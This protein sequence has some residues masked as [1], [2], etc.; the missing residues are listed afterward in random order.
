MSSGKFAGPQTSENL[1]S[2]SKDL[3]LGALASVSPPARQKGVHRAKNYRP[4]WNCEVDALRKEILCIRHQQKA[5]KA[6]GVVDAARDKNLKT[7][8]TKMKRDSRW[9]REKYNRAE[10]LKLIEI[11]R[12]KTKRKVLWD[13]V[14]GRSK[15]SFDGI[16]KT[17]ELADKDG[18]LISDAP[19]VCE[20]FRSEYEHLGSDKPPPGNTF[21]LEE[22]ERQI[23]AY[24]SIKRLALY[25]GPADGPIN[26][27]EI[28][29]C[30][31]HLKYGK[32]SGLDHISTDVLK[33]AH[34]PIA[35]IFVVLFNR[36][37]STGLPPADWGKAAVAII[38][39]A[40]DP[41]DWANYRLISLLSVVGKLFEAVLNRR[42]V[43]LL[44]KESLLNQE[45]I[46]CR[47]KGYRCQD[48]TFVLA[49]TIKSMARRRKKT[50]CGFLDVRKAYPTV[51]RADLMEKLH[52]KLSKASGGDSRYRC[53]LWSVIDKLY[54]N[55][56]SR[57]VIQDSVSDEYNVN[58]GLREGSVLSPILYAI[59][60]DGI[61]AEM[62]GCIGVHVH[63]F[64][65]KALLY[66]D[67]IVLVSES[68]EDLQN[69][70][71]CCQKYAD[72]HSFQF[73]MKK[74]QVVV[75]GQDE[76][77]DFQWKLMGENMSQV[78]HYKY[79]GLTFR[80]CLG[81]SAIH[82][83]TLALLRLKYVGRKFIDDGPN[84]CLVCHKSTLQ[85]DNTS[86]IAT[87]L[88]CDSCEGDVHRECMGTSPVPPGD[89]NCPACRAKNAPCFPIPEERIITSIRLE[90]FS[91]GKLEYH[92]VT[93]LIDGDNPHRNEYAFTLE[94]LHEIMDGNIT[95]YSQKYGVRQ[96]P[97]FGTE[98]PWEE[99]KANTKRK[100]SI[101]R[102]QL[103][104]M[105]CHT[106]G[107]PAWISKQVVQTLVVATAMFNTEIWQDGAYCPEIQ[108]EMN[109]IY[110]RLIDVPSC[111]NN[112]AIHHE[113]GL[114]DQEFR[115]KVAA[116][117]FRN[118]VIGLPAHRLVK[119]M[120]TAL[121][122]EAAPA[123][124]HGRN[125]DSSVITYL[126][127]LALKL[128]W[129]GNI[130]ACAAT[131]KAHETRCFLQKE[132]LAGLSADSATLVAL[133]RLSSTPKTAPYLLRDPSLYWSHRLG[134]ALKIK[135][136]CNCREALGKGHNLREVKGR[137]TRANSHTSTPC[138]HQ[139]IGESVHHVLGVCGAYKAPR[140]ACFARIETKVPSFVDLTTTQKVDYVLS[141][142]NSPAVDID[143]Y[144]FLYKVHHIRAKLVDPTR[145]GIGPSGLDGSPSG[146][147]AL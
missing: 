138:C 92:A 23:S 49:E 88:H 18:H 38:F 118:H 54:E 45:Q 79:L 46:G 37:L 71:D 134:K 62:H 43:S 42:I 122:A 113:C 35:R 99:A 141:D 89:F 65:Y 116:L 68:A 139:K 14:L 25:Q 119:Q 109:K 28:T 20:K 3:I 15:Q 146:L 13:V 24:G 95:A 61:I 144:R 84:T 4:W 59:F 8:K 123:L 48:H 51:L 114:I 36:A 96:V 32:A 5:D 82:G 80:R 120:Y 66:V 50:F 105:G 22:R 102:N 67:D 87:V 85:A 131:I 129:R 78:A 76:D 145:P 81:H 126:E 7:L 1:W 69:M 53:H 70:L 128:H 26:F 10:N 143:I 103:D 91:S 108:I 39:K 29:Q 56:S 41:T 142:N 34:E 57:V 127:P 44:D 63:R 40:G 135:L 74:S 75:F 90:R 132:K 31:K 106:M 33:I 97:L 52:S 121:L 133:K 107:L 86:V 27:D 93:E 101:L 83:S 140:D 124:K 47:G 125:V 110:R 77:F 19:S 64:W 6:S 73:S 2:T 21:N 94:K 115:A 98:D 112:A 136:R 137:L 147:P 16:A 9:A 17:I 60:I 58:H 111:T 72:E 100:L 130:G 117:K 11:S 55:C 12:D 30:I 104:L